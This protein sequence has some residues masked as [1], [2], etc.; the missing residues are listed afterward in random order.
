MLTQQQAE[1]VALAVINRLDPYWPDRPPHVITLVTPHRLGWLFYYQSEEYI[2]TGSVSAML[3]G[4]GPIL[5]SGSDGSYIAVGTAA[6]FEARL[7]EAEIE[8]ERVR[9]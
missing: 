3:A 6:P 5:V 7:L 8:L 4:N 1:A 2:R 9:R